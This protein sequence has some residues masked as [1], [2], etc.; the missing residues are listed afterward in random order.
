MSEYSLKYF[1]Q[2]NGKDL[3]LAGMSAIGPFTTANPKE[4]LRF[5]TEQAA[6]QHPAYCHPTCLLNV[7]EA[8]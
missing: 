4:A 5:P 1:K 7:C 3:W 6:M 2:H 8:P